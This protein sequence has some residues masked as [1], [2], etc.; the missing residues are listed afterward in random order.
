[1]TTIT[2][3]V[4]YDGTCEEAFNFYAA[5]FKGSSLSLD[6]F[7]SMPNAAEMPPSTQNKIMHAALT[8]GNQGMIMGSDVVPGMGGDV[9]FGNSFGLTLQPDSEEE[10]AR[11]FN[12]LSEGGTVTMPLEKTFWN[13]TFG[14]FTDKFGVNWMVNYDHK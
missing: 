12:A 3:Y 7:S 2:A 6:R 10:A 9:V 4:N 14:M 5:V 1:M 8:L 11:L 13:A